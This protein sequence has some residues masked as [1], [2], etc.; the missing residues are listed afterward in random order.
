MRKPEANSARRQRSLRDPDDSRNRCF[1]PH[2]RISDLFA[3]GSIGP[4]GRRPA[5]S[6]GTRLCQQRGTRSQVRCGQ[7][8]E[9]RY[10]EPC[11]GQMNT[12]SR[13]E[14][15]NDLYGTRRNSSLTSIYLTPQLFGP[16]Q[17]HTG[18]IQ[19]LGEIHF[20]FIANP[21]PT[22]GHKNIAQTN[23]ITGAVMS[24]RIITIF[25]CTAAWSDK[26]MTS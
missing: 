12:A 10:S 3:S 7:V 22:M 9:S 24:A 5:R 21:R 15:A 18:Q 8:P 26:E 23:P 19:G 17:P 20:R 11:A 4:L 13:K 25:L 16:R 6:L 14:N 1:S 2:G